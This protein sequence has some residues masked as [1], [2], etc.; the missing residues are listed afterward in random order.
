MLSQLQEYGVHVKHSKCYFLR[1]S[2]QYLGHCIDAEAVHATEKKIEAIVGAP[3]IVADL[4]SL[5]TFKLLWM[6]SSI[7]YH[8]YSIHYMN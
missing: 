6:F 7:I 3:E 4:R 1:E 8:P 2:V 5:G